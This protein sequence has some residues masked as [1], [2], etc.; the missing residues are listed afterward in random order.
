MRILVD[1]NVFLDHFLGRG[2]DGCIATKFFAWCYLN[3]NQIY[4]AS[5]SFRDIE[6][7][8]MKSF[9]NHQEAR[10]VSLA[11]YSLCSKVIG[12]SAD[13]AIE[14][15]FSDNKDYEDECLIQAAQEQLLD[16]IVTNNV[17]DFSESDIPCFKP[18]DL[19]NNPNLKHVKLD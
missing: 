13:A 17:K 8:A 2:N 7:I 6:Y 10:K 15:L 9:H 14:S 12:I 19:M 5:S 16:A 11:A 3:K 1:T 4:I 18:E